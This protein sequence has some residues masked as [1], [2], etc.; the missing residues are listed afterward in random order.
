MK[1]SQIASTLGAR[2]D[3]ADVEITG[4]A[5]IEEAKPGQ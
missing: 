1:L 2:L 3:G 5:G 4:V